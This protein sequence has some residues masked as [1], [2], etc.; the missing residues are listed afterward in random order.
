MTTTTYNNEAPAEAP[1]ECQIPPP[2]SL[3]A[4]ALPHSQPLPKPA[5]PITSKPRGGAPAGNTNALTKATKSTQHPPRGSKLHA[6]YAYAADLANRR[7][8]AVAAE[9]RAK[10]GG[11]APTAAQENQL[12]QI[13]LAEA[14]DRVAGMLLGNGKTF[15]GKPLSIPEQNEQRA[16]QRKAQ[17]AIEV[18]LGKLGLGLD[19]AST[20]KSAPA[21]FYD[22][23]GANA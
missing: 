6:D 17:E 23:L 2:P 16:I 10:S 21:S 20:P 19:S 22:R 5:T 15:K 3:S 11:K 4:P 13:W 18:A 7:V 1:N 14:S 8:K 9:L 12:R